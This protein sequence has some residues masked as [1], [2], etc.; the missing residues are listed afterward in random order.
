MSEAKVEPHRVRPLGRL[1]LQKPALGKDWE[2]SLPRSPVEP[3]QAVGPDTRTPPS[4]QAKRLQMIQ[5]WLKTG[6][7]QPLF[8]QPRLALM[9]G[10]EDKLDDGPTGVEC[11]S[12]MAFKRRTRPRP[13]V[14]K[15][16][17]IS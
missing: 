2:D 11:E 16:Q 8:G 9:P 15:P 1:P 6:G 14:A 4:D 13:S 17:L 3:L 12:R 7:G 5:R 10:L